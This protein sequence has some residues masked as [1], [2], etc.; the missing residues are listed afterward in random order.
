MQ[1]SVALCSRKKHPKDS[2]PQGVHHANSGS[3]FSSLTVHV[4]HV[5]YFGCLFTALSTHNSNP[6][7]K[8]SPDNTFPIAS[9]C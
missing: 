7:L 3:S 4:P 9:L 8:I 2:D 6:H 5:D 1:M